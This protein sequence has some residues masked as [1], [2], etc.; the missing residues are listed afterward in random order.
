MHAESSKMFC[1]CMA[2]IL[3]IKS[4]FI[5]PLR[6]TLDVIFD[7]NPSAIFPTCREES[8]RECKAKAVIAHTTIIFSPVGLDCQCTSD[9]GNIRERIIYCQRILNFTILS[10][11]GQKPIF[12]HNKFT[13]DS[14]TVSVIKHWLRCCDNGGPCGLADD[15]TAI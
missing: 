2:H 12:D 15:Y 4:L 6:I 9:R 13:R 5:C 7:S 1:I 8:S 3:F 14:C 11:L 10:N